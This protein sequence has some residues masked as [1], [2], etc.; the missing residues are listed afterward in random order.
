MLTYLFA[1]LAAL[2]NAIS[3]VLQRKADRDQPA[4]DNLSLRL[5]GDLLRD[6]VWF[7]G[8]LGVIAGF[9]LQAAALGSGPLAVVEPV[10]IIELPITLLLA[11]RI[12]HR[13]L[14]AR[15]W[16][17]ALAMTAGLAGLLFFLAPAGG[18][19]FGVPLWRW[20]IGLGI[21]L[22]VI[23]ALV[24]AARRSASN[25]RQAAL[26]GI[27]TGTAFGLTAAL[28]KAMTDAFARH[29]F[30]AIF[31]TWQTYA[32]VATGALA[33]FLLQSA[34]NAGPLVAAQPGFTAADPVVSILWGVLAFGETV[35]G[36]IYVL[37]AVISAGIVAVGIAGLSRSPLVA[38][39]DQPPADSQEVE[40]RA[41]EPRAARPSPGG[42]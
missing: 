27:A 31:V 5:I 6:P 18:T 4:E 11:S 24:A 10:L 2:A 16:S 25:T 41:D 38:G 26:L 34:L 9:L 17:A 19:G 22:A 12:F 29:G 21:N 14:D 30:S 28:I 13:R 23:A 8:I 32:M 40:D 39:E 15:E 20:G 7:L 42:T 35:R 36:G 3:S 1:A 37:L 33:M